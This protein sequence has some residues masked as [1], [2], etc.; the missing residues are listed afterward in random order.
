MVANFWA[1]Q[2]GHYKVTAPERT[3]E[4]FVGNSYGKPFFVL[5]IPDSTF[6]LYFLIIIKL[7]KNNAISI[8]MLRTV[9]A[10]H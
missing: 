1:P 4:I 10:Q 3:A 6:N 5:D 8:H 9:K 7:I 2:R